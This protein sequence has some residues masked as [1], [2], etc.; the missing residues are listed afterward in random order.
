[1]LALAA[2]KQKFEDFR[3]DALPNFRGR[4]VIGTFYRAGG[5]QKAERVFQFGQDLAF[6]IHDKLLIIAACTQMGI[7]LIHIE[8]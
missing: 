8:I 2:E 6:A 7:L 1:L 4:G 3:K 5:A